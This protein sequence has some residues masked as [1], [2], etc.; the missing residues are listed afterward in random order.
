MS[1]IRRLPHM[2]WWEVAWNVIGLF[3]LLLAAGGITW[4]A[5]AIVG[6]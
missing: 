3:I 5:W 1:D 4:L 2:S 6:P